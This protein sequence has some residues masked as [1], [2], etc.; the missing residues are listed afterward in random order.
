[1]NS[2]TMQNIRL[3]TELAR[4]VRY[5][6]K[7]QRRRILPAWQDFDPTTQPLLAGHLFAADPVE[8]GADYHYRSFGALM[9]EFFGFDMRGK[10]LSE[11]P[12]ETFRTTIRE[13]Y[14]QVVAAK[15]PIVHAVE[16]SWPDGGRYG[17]HYVLIPFGTADGVVETILGGVS[18]A[19]TREDLKPFRGSGIASFD[20]L[21]REIL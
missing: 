19:L 4:L 20:E 2:A 16:L 10:R 21:R 1:M 6:Q 7:L 3:S 11:A 17:L 13:T 8:Q 15:R 18:S 5:C 9:P 14:D 12:D